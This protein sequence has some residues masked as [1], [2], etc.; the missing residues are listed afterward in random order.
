MDT[1]HHW[2][3]EWTYKIVT[4]WYFNIVTPVCM[5]WKI[6]IKKTQN[7][8]IELYWYLPGFAACYSLVFNSCKWIT[9]FKENF[10][11]AFNV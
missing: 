4:E 9:L 2:L 7:Q 8:K 10:L 6:T 11:I 1:L 5:S 3:I